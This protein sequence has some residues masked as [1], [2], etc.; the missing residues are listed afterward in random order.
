M[1]V[2]QNL[3]NV[4]AFNGVISNALHKSL[5]SNIRSTWLDAVGHCVM[6]ALT[7]S[8]GLYIFAVATNSCMPPMV[9]RSLRLG[10]KWISKWV[11]LTKHERIVSLSWPPQS[12]ITSW[13][14]FFKSWM[15]SY[16]FPAPP[17]SIWFLLV[18]FLIGLCSTLKSF[19]VGRH[20]TKLCLCLWLVDR[21]KGFELDSFYQNHLFTCY[22]Y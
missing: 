2:Q 18:D 19:L 5:L 16:I 3:L 4:T 22:Q 14:R 7:S 6:T 20:P 10:R 9:P 13:Y 15:V 1:N 12:I 11:A 21:R 17:L 8:M